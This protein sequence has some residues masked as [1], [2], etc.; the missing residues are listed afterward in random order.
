MLRINSEIAIGDNE[1]SFGFSR[2]SGPGGQNVNKVSTAVQLR[3]DITDSPSLPDDVKNRLIKLAGN[4]VTADGILLIDARRSRSQSQN[5]EEALERLKNLILKA[6]YKPKQ[7]KK[8]KPTAT[9][10]EKR[11]KQ[12]KARS[13]LK[14]SRKRVNES[15]D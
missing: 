5:R 3:F 10:K 1:I 14:D 7:R 15:D 9:S 11:L 8:T 2:S 6:L 12:K 4:R 13:K